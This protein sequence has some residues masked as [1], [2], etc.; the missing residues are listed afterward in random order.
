MRVFLGMI[1]GAVLAIV[2]SY[3]YDASTGR[4]P[5]GLLSTAGDGQAPMVNWDVVAARWH[6]LEVGAQ[7]L[8]ADIERGWK[9]LKG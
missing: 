8:A 2:G 3:L 9:R 7:E 1:L 5:N 6:G 4:A